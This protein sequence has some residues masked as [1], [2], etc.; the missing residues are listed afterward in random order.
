MERYV[1]EV[2]ERGENYI[3]SVKTHMHALMHAHLI[4]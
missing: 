1:R 2:R 3:I 4:D